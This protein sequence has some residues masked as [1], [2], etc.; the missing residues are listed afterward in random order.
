[1][2]IEGTAN[3]IAPAVSRAPASADSMSL[4]GARL[5]SELAAMRGAGWSAVRAQEILNQGVASG[6]PFYWLG[7]AMARSL[8]ER[9]GAAAIGRALRTDGLG[10][11]RAYLA[12]RPRAGDALLSPEVEEWVRALT[13]QRP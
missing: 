9:D 7:A 2:L 8:V 4:A 12:S 13:D 3:Y 5:L 11:A 6:G 10:F 1:L